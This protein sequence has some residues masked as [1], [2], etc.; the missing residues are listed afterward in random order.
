MKFILIFGPPAVGKMTVGKALAAET[1]LKLFHNH[2][3]LELVN[4]FFDFGTPSFRRLDKEIRFSIFREVAQ[5]DLAGLIFTFVWEIK[6]GG[7]AKYV[8]E[9]VDIFE[10]NGADTH[11]VE[12]KADL[13]VRLIRNIQENRLLEKPSK[14]DTVASEKRLLSAER[15]YQFNTGPDDLTEL[16]ILKIDNTHLKPEE[17]ARQIKEHFS[18]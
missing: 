5:S 1:D 2:M 13:N 6:G 18:L 3:S 10:A 12:L 16:G 17:V 9:I 7:D 4:Q 15:K 11:Y 14:R 8:Q